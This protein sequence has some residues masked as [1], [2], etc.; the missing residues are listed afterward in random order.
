MVIRYDNQY[1][2]QLSVTQ[3][4]SDNTAPIYVTYGL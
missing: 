4:Y 1:V 2:M 3:C